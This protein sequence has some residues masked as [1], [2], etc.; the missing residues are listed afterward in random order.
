MATA[1]T[2][3]SRAPTP[4]AFASRQSKQKYPLR[5]NSPSQSGVFNP[6]VLLAFVLCSVG[7]LLA[8]LSFAATPQSEMAR[9]D[10]NSPGDSLFGDKH[11]GSLSGNA[12]AA[13]VS[14]WSIVPS[15]NTNAAQNN[16]LNSVTCTSALD[17]WAVGYYQTDASNLQTLILRWNGTSWAIVPSPNPNPLPS[18]NTLLTGVT[19]TS[20]TDCW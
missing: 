11:A 2:E 16:Y 4:K 18:Q 7:I 9:L 5:K 12:N 8:M 14:D 1:L 19:C 20:A 17:C 15:P 6:R 3:Q 10:A 13:A